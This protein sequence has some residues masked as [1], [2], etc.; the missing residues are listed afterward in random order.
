[1]QNC[2]HLDDWHTWKGFLSYYTGID[3]AN[4]TAIGLNDI[5]KTTALMIQEAALSSSVWNIIDQ[6]GPKALLA[7]SYLSQQEFFYSPALPN[8][9]WQRE[10]A[11]WFSIGLAQ[12]QRS[13]AV[14]YRRP[15]APILQQY[16][17]NFPANAT[18]IRS[19]CDSQKVHD[20]RFT[21][22]NVLGLGIA[23][24]LGLLILICGHGAPFFVPKI[25]RKFASRR[26]QRS[27]PRDQWIASHHLHLQRMVFQLTGQGSWSGEEDSVPVTAHR[28]MLEP[29]PLLIEKSNLDG[30]LLPYQ[31]RT[32][33]PM[34]HWEQRDVLKS[35][36]IEST[37]TRS[38]SEER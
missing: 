1:M 15:I 20:A 14:S 26:Q 8:T 17:Q 21:T 33:Q 5:Q 25:Q 24:G 32:I 30:D 9:Q 12:L 16:W 31:S 4:L 27:I 23:L 13:L 11:N 10:V 19:F 37:D 18:A 36:A 34:Q 38:T 28:E 22:F 35:P 7:S 2:T 6:L 29:L 3:E